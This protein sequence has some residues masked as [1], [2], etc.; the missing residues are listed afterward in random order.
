[1][2]RLKFYLG[3]PDP[4]IRAVFT[5]NTCSP[6]TG[7]QVLSYKKEI[8]MLTAWQKFVLEVDPDIVIGYNITQFDISYLLNRAQILK[9]SDFAYLGRL[10][11]E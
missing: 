11:C 2:L 1:M 9:L 7:A 5:L 6:I 3:Q 4:F 8:D 10:K